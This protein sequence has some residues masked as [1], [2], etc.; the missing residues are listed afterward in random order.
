MNSSFSKEVT[1]IC[2]QID[3]NG[4]NDSIHLHIRNVEKSKKVSW[5]VRCN[6]V[7]ETF[8]KEEYDRRI[9]IAQIQF[10]L[11]EQSQMR[12]INKYNLVHPNYQLKRRTEW[13]EYIRPFPTPE[14]PNGKRFVITGAKSFS[15]P[16]VGHPVFSFS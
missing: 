3:G 5:N 12:E 14:S 11:Y 9:D 13:S 15:V 8:S 10:N 4:C 6:E 7:N 2:K 16:S 1:P